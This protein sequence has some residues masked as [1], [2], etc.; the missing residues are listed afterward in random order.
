MKTILNLG[1]GSDGS[2]LNGG[3]DSGS[4]HFGGG[5]DGS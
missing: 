5:I 4:Y 2:R 3:G 1:G